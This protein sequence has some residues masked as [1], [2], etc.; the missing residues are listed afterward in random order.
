MFD[1]FIIVFRSVE[2]LMFD[3]EIFI[4]FYMNV[5]GFEVVVRQGDKVFLF[6]SGDDFYVFELKLGCEV[7]LCKVMFWVCF[8]SDLDC[9]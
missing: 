5:W 7:V 6:V 1:F 4:V 9:F 2:F 8:E 3:I